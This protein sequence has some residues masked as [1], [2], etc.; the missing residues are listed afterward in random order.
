MAQQ[1]LMDQFPFETS[2]QEINIID[3]PDECELRTR[4]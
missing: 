1:K 4:N 3:N 2:Q